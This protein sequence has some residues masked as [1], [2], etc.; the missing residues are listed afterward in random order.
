LRHSYPGA[1][2]K[3]PEEGSYFVDADPQLFDHILRYLRRGVLPIFYDNIR[4]H[5][6]GLYRALLEEARYFQ[7][8]RLENWLS[9]KSYI[10]KK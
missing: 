9:D 8:D 3:T 1:G 5:D 7:I 2:K 10:F 4:G 6:H